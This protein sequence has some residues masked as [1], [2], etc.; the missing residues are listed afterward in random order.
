MALGLASA[1]VT[2]TCSPAAQADFYVFNIPAGDAEDSIAIFSQQAQRLIAA[3]GDA[4]LDIKAPPV[5]GNYSPEDAL[6]IILKYTDL[7]VAS[8][9]GHI[10]ILRRHAVRVPTRA[11]DEPRP[12]MDAAELVT[13][14]GYRASLASST[15]AKRVAV[16]FSDTIFAEDIGKFPDTNVAEAFNRVPGITIS[17][18]ITGEGLNVAIR[19]LGTNFTKV[20]LNNAPVAVA[21]TGRTDAQNA[22]REVDLNMFPVELIARLSVAKSPTASMIEGGAAGTVNMRSARPF[23]DEGFHINYSM[24][25]QINSTSGK[26]GE[27]A[28]L[29]VSNTWGSTFG[30]LVGMS[31]HHNLV[32]TQGFE[33]IGW[34]NPNLS[35]A[36]CGASIGC[37][38]TGGGNWTI[39]TTAPTNASTSALGIAGATIDKAWLLAHNP[40]LTSITQLDDGLLP[41]LG[42]LADQAGHRDRANAI[43]SIEYMPLPDMHLY[44]DTLFGRTVNQELRTDMT[45]QVRNS[46]IIPLDVEVDSNDV[47]TKGTYANANLFL[48]LRPYVEKG[49]FLSF[50]PGMEWLVTERLSIDL[51]ANAT[52]SHFFRDYPTIGLYSQPTT[53]TYD[54]TSGK[55]PT[56]TSAIDTNDIHSWGWLNER[57]SVA[58][59]KRYTYTNGVHLVVAYAGNEVK[60]TIGG[61]YDDV[62]RNIRANIDNTAWQ[63]AVC[64]NNPS[65]WLPPPNTQ[66]TCDGVDTNANPDYSGYGTGYT[67]GMAPLIWSGSLIP[68]SEIYKYLLPGP[69]GYTTLNWNAF[70]K[71]SH[72]DLFAAEAPAVNASNTGAKAGTISEK[73]SGIFVQLDGMFHPYDLDLNYDIGLRWV[74]THQRVGGLAYNSSDPRNATLSDG[75]YYPAIPVFINAKRT[76][77]TFLPSMNLVFHPTDNLQIRFSA[78]RTITRP[79]PSAMVPSTSFSSP[80]ADVV[81]VGNAALNPY[82][83]N[84]VDLGAEYYTGGEGYVGLAVFRKMI[85]GF[86]VTGT[87]THPFADLA[88]YGITYATL[89]QTQQTA[90]DARGG[91]TQAV[92]VFN[93]QVNASGLLRVKGF[94]FNWVQPLDHLLERYGLKGFGFSANATIIKQNGSGGTPAV[95]MGVPN[96]TYDLVGYYESERAMLR[97]AYVN[98]AG[99]IES[100]TNQN[101]ITA[102]RVCG[103]PYAQLD[104][105]A[106]YKLS[107]LIGDLPSNPEITVDVLNLTNATQRDY[108]QYSHA[109]YSYY[110]TGSSVL[111]GI[112]GAF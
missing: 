84:N 86:T 36:Q 59:E 40:K 6:A 107:Q 112:R 41:R 98:Y 22:N 50:N 57:T 76:Y 61:A 70:K 104:L 48:E 90:I 95:A 52:R 80:S 37:N 92:V 11:A 5:R 9:D 105:S 38:A 111:F 75:G 82:Y 94:E 13:V 102:A 1:C 23:D 30:I 15:N 67:T 83:S 26:V 2:L 32:R 42:R 44:I 20:L 66:P 106:S 65:T 79:D 81:S 78:S 108:F 64:G 8:D 10:V 110:K 45:F 47:V 51:K 7:E 19:G 24:Q 54:A 17:R 34:T 12:S 33:T 25:G 93:Q 3:P 96:Y 109:T 14:A 18:E 91:P 27:N 55:F 69:Q 85:S 46:A 21:S 56:F 35:A 31:I 103:D 4:L 74:E 73:V 53:V 49:D 68:N 62:Y 101:A 88:A 28:T 87:S 43:A 16:E 60:L 71:A 72:Y 77:Q 99:T 29:I 97:L 58:Q 39:P 100:D 89:T 63:T